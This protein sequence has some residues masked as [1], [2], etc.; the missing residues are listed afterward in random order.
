MK[1]M[2]IDAYEFEVTVSNSLKNTDGVYKI[3]AWD[4]N[5]AIFRL[6]RQIYIAI[7]NEGTY[8]T[9]KKK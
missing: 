2:G 9:A 6:K 8:I 3:L 5:N 1:I 4:K 7:S